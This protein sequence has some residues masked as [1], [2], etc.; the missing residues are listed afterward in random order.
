VQSYSFSGRRHRSRFRPRPSLKLADLEE[1]RIL[2]AVDEAIEA[3]LICEVPGRPQ[4]FT[5][6]HALIR[7]TLYGELTSTRR[8]R[9]HRRVG[10]AIEQLAEG[11]PTPPLADLAYHFA[12][13]AACRRG[14]QSD[15]LCDSRWRPGGG[16][17]GAGGGSAPV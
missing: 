17:G 16:R 13:A 11:S 5:F 8:V 4:R 2:D 7:E 1:D 9:L 10:E 14:R 15:R 12:Q 6:L 3:R